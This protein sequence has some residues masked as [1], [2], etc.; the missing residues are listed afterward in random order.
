M[1]DT[2]P[3]YLGSM[4]VKWLC[5]PALLGPGYVMTVGHVVPKVPQ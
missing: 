1:A 3:C 5:F 2:F 4:L